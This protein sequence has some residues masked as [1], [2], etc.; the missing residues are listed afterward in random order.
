MLDSK[1]PEASKFP[2]FFEFFLKSTINSL[3]L[4]KISNFYAF[5][6]PYRDFDNMSSS[7][8]LSNL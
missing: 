4:I 8:S 6:A 1:I 5:A 7:F 2:F 3:H